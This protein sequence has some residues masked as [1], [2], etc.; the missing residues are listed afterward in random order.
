MTENLGRQT[1]D[2]N[3]PI[4]DPNLVPQKD[5]DTFSESS[6]RNSEAE[7]VGQLLTQFGG[8]NFKGFKDSDLTASVYYKSNSKDV[9]SPSSKA[10]KA[11]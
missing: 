10:S 9:R 5:N 4:Y 7:I 8:N 3:G 11:Y 6:K 2:L 1:I